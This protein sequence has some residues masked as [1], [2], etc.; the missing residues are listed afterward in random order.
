MADEEKRGKLTRV[1]STGGVQLDDQIQWYN[2]T[3]KAKEKVLP[4]IEKLRVNVGKQVILKL[5]GNYWNGITIVTDE[6]PEKTIIDTVKKEPGSA[7]KDKGP[8]DMPKT[9]PKKE[10][11]KKAEPEPEPVKKEEQKKEEGPGED[12]PM[13]GPEEPLIT[14]HK[15]LNLIQQKLKV[16]KSQENKFAHF[17]YRNMSDILEG[18][19]PLLK[20]YNVSIVLSDEVVQVGERIYIK[21]TAKLIDSKTSKHIEAIGYAREAKEK[22]GMDDAQIT[23]SA[24]SY[25]RKYAL[26]GLLAIDDT[27][28]IDSNKNDGT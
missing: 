16:P 4:K 3:M 11:E 25:A 1:A 9:E 26:N 12:G 5:I 6:D 2:P 22:K 15:K 17:N 14:I 8:N 20:L 19:K 13:V 10:P 7:L 28:D 23:G 21:A 27:E 24:S 18:L